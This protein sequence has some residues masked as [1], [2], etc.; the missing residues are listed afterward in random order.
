MMMLVIICV[1]DMFVCARMCV[2]VCVCFCV[3]IYECVRVFGI[4]GCSFNF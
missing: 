4:F 3:C 1:D 2:C